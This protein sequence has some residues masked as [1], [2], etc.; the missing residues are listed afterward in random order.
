MMLRRMGLET[1]LASNGADAIARAVAEP[2]DVVFMD[3]RM[4]GIDGLEAT[5][6]IRQ[7]LAGRKLR[8]VALTANAMEEDRAACLAAGMD[9]FITKPVGQEELRARLAAWLTG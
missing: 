6:R 2:W 5:R 9:D 4:P 3:V 8:I 7:Q 1:A